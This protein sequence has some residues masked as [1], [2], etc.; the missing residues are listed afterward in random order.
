VAHLGGRYTVPPLSEGDMLDDI[1]DHRRQLILPAQRNLPNLMKST[2][3]LRDLMKS[4]FFMN[5]VK[6]CHILGPRHRVRRCGTPNPKNWEGLPAPPKQS[7][8]RPCRPQFWRRPWRCS[9]S[10]WSA[11]GV[12][13]LCRRP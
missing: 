2:V 13:G 6:L 7:S 11:R 10:S 4:T 12:G 1:I 5:S 9:N 8:Q 3:F